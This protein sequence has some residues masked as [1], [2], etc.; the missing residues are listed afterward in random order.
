VPLGS[1]PELGPTVELLFAEA[2]DKKEG[3]QAAVDRLA[4]YFLV[5]LL[6]SAMDGKLIEGGIVTAL[7]DSHLGNVVTKMHEEP[8]RAWTLEELG[9][10]A[11][12]S[13]ARFAAHFLSVMGMTPFEY[14]GRWRIGVAQ[15]ML[16]KGEPLKMVAPSVGYASAG[17]L[18]RSFAQYVGLS[19]IAWL[20]ARRKGEIQ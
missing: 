6:R 19:P 10:I 9:Q 13:R 2:F 11:G 7:S 18:S 3:R 4:E 17:A 20:N 8:E 12:M 1:M 16:K 5:L 15:S 14:L